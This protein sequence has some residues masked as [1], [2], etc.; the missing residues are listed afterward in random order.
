MERSAIEDCRVKAVDTPCVTAVFLHVCWVGCLEDNVPFA[1]DHLKVR[2]V[3]P[4]DG[5][6]G[7]IRL[8]QNDVIQRARL[9]V[10]SKCDIGQRAAIKA[11]AGSGSGEKDD[12]RSKPHTSGLLKSHKKVL[13]S[14]L[15][16]RL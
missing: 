15:R 14:G 2:T 3:R 11:M 8:V 7:P 13:R 12:N 4:I 6:H 1:F 9:D 16:Q 10:K 5:N